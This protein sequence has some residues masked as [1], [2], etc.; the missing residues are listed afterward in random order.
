MRRRINRRLAT[1]IAA[2]LLLSP[3]ASA[4]VVTCTNCGTEFTQ[5]ANNVQLVDQLARQVELVQ[6]ALLRYENKLL[7]TKGLD[8]QLFGE[9]L[10]E[11]RKVM[12]ALGQAQSLSVT[13]TSLDADF[14]NK[15]KDYEAY[16][17]DQLGVDGLADKYQQWSEDTNSSVLTSLKAAREQTQQLEGSEETLFQ[18][19]EQLATTA[20]GRMQALQVANQIALAGARQTQKLRQLLTIHL[21]LQANF[22]QTQMDREASQGAALN[23][24]VTTGRET[25]KTGDGK[26]F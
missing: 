3:C 7:H 8:D 1:V 19:L 22:I 24:F 10:A 20:E 18:G 21:Q 14:R 16:V 5:L 25:V 11:L 17:K 6:N 13:S 2:S 4:L 26:W 12:G 23:T 9:A 15:F